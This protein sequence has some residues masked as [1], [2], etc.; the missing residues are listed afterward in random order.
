MRHKHNRSRCALPSTLR[1]NLMAALSLF[2]C[3]SVW[4]QSNE[5]P[6]ENQALQDKYDP[7]A[8]LLGAGECR[9]LKQGLEEAG[10]TNS[11]PNKRE[12]V[13]MQN[14]PIPAGNQIGDFQNACYAA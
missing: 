7:C 1:L 13:S 3:G 12:Q 2:A 9:D 4:S 11:E 6:A 14:S 8:N 5:R 10:Q